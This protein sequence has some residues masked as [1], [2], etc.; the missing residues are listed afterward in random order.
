MQKWHQLKKANQMVHNKLHCWMLG[1]IITLLLCMF[2]SFAIP[3]PNSTNMEISKCYGDPVIWNKNAFKTFRSNT[4]DSIAIYNLGMS[5]LCMEQ[6]EQAVKYFKKASQKG[7]IQ[8]TFWLALYYETDKTLDLSHDVTTIYLDKVIYYYRL[9]HTQIAQALEYPYGIHED[10][11]ALENRHHTS[12]KVAISLPNMYFN[13]YSYILNKLLNQG[14]IVYHVNYSSSRST[15]NLLLSMKNYADDC[16]RR[17]FPAQWLK[18][19]VEIRK[20]QQIQCLA[21]SD[22]ATRALPLEVQRLQIA[23]SQCRGA[24]KSCPPHNKIM[25]QL[26]VLFKKMKTKALSVTIY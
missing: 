26:V 17:P 9:A 4:E 14:F 5:F 25:Q 10:M 1:V 18:E 13:Y 12:A 23:T 24:L 2:S 8:A 3:V 15:I 21:M 22:F 11:Y 6:L 7:H 16:L 19:E 20:N